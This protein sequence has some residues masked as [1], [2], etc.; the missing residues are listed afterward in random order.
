MVVRN[1]KTHFR[2]PRGKR[3]PE[4]K[5]VFARSPKIFKKSVFRKFYTC[6]ENDH[7]DTYNA[8]WTTVPQ[9]FFL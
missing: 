2:A 7:M 8:A 6:N 5:K 9:I 1:R 3:S 4:S